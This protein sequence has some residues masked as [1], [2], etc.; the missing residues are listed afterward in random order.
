MYISNRSIHKRVC[1]GNH[2]HV[3]ARMNEA[4]APN[5]VLKIFMMKL[6]V[7]HGLPR[8]PDWTC[9]KSSQS[10][11][12]LSMTQLSGQFSIKVSASNG[13][14]RG[15][16]ILRGPTIKSEAH[17]TQVSL[18]LAQLLQYNRCIR[19]QEAISSARCNKARETVHAGT[20]K[21]DLVERLFGLELSVSVSYDRVMEISHP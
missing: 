17:D 5:D 18:S 14:L 11:Q 15:P 8:L 1:P 7:L 3:Q 21:R 9:S 13:I 4:M 12:V 10:S 20:R 16:I 19:R 2:I 6:S